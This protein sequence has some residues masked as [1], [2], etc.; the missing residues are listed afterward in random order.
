MKNIIYY[1]VVVLIPVLF[2]LAP[3]V[4]ERL[5]DMRLVRAEDK[6]VKHLMNNCI[7]TLYR[8]KVYVSVCWSGPTIQN[9]DRVYT[10]L[11]VKD[12]DTYS[13]STDGPSYRVYKF[14]FL[15][16][17]DNTITTRAMTLEDFDYYFSPA[18][19]DDKVEAFSI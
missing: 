1:I 19:E 3:I 6:R 17:K 12:T 16:M 9:S 14:K 8:E 13:G 5:R 10:L 18:N 2:F 4:A 11:E 7:G 15:L